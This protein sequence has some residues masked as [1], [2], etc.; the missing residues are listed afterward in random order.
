[1]SK[2]IAKYF[3]YCCI[4]LFCTTGGW[5][6]TLWTS[7]IRS[8]CCTAPSLSSAPSSPALL[9]VQDQSMRWELKDSELWSTPI[10]YYCDFGW[11]LKLVKCWPLPVIEYSWISKL[12]SPFGLSTTGQTGTK[13]RNRSNVRLPSIST[14]LWHGSR[15]I[16]MTNEDARSTSHVLTFNWFN[17]LFCLQNSTNLINLIPSQDQLDDETLFPSKIGVP[18]PPNFQVGQSSNA[19]LLRVL[20]H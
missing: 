6:W 12:I 7:S 16:I 8:T 14:S 20:L 2:K 13:W 18:F 15:Y 10:N 11:T 9:W 17:I 5:R 4:T 3:V 19:P 1:M